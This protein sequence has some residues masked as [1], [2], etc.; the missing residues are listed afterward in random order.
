MYFNPPKN[1]IAMMINLKNG[2]DQL[3]GKPDKQYHDEDGNVIWLYNK[4]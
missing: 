2:I 1:K 4:Q 3:Y